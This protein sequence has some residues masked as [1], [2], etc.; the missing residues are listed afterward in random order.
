MD[1]F[2]LPLV[3][4]GRL[5][6]FCDRYPELA[7]EFL[8]SEHVG[9]LVSGGM[10]LA[11]RFG[12]PRFSTLVSRKLIEA[13]ILTVAS[14]RSL[15]RYG[16][17]AHHSDLVHHRF[18][19]FVDPHTGRPFDWEF[20]RCEKSIEV[21]T[22]G[23]LTFADPKSMI[24]ECIAGTGIAQLIGWGVGQRLAGGG[25]STFF[26]TGMASAFR[27]SPSTR[28]ASIRPRRSAPS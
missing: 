3:L 4:A 22:S 10:D 24:E 28:H 1:P 21:Q 12:Q 25:W 15:E 11:I 2:F 5:G 27:S 6:A 19:Q 8:T 7:I 14:P 16:R 9:D 23:P 26:L 13:P 18:L 20:V 17:P